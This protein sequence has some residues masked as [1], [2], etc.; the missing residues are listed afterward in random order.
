[1]KI[2]DFFKGLADKAGIVSPDLD[3]V[4]A[5]SA[6]ADIEIPDSFNN[7]INDRYLTRERALNDVNLVSEIQKKSNKS[8][9]DT[10][11]AKIID[12]LPFVS[13]EELLTKI[14][15][16]SQSFQKWDLLKAGL[17]NTIE[18]IKGNEKNKVNVDANKILEEKSKELKTLK[19]EYEARLKTQENALNDHHVNYVLSNKVLAH[20]FADAYKPLKENITS[21]TIDKL[22]KG[23]KIALDKGELKVFKSVDGSDSLVEA[24]EGNEKVTIDKLIEK[25][26]QPFIAVSNA[27]IQ[28]KKEVFV[29]EQ[30]DIAKLSLAEIRRQQVTTLPN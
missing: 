29:P 7:Q 22:R 3:V 27:V 21:L 25:E 5:A 4:M 9:Y 2:K 19:D 24:F 20:N 23:Y 16:E 15:S 6:L 13:D 10:F 18:N 28:E 14:K 12:F 30:R 1:M 26:V 17:K 8:A 11:D